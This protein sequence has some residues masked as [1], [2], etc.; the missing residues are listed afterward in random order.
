MNASFLVMGLGVFFA[1]AF[2]CAALIAFVIGPVAR[3]ASRLSLPARRA[4]WMLLAAAPAAAGATA[5]V[6]ALLP[7]FGLAPDH[8]LVHAAHHPHLCLHHPQELSVPAAI[9]ALVGLLRLVTTAVGE[10]RSWL[11]ARRV[12]S[13]LSSIARSDGPL[14]VFPGHTP[15]AFV[16]GATRPKVFVSEAMMQLP[17]PLL[18]P[19]LAHERCHAARRHLLARLVVRLLGALHVPLV[20]RRISERLAAAHE[21]EADEA[22]RAATGDGI[23]VAESLLRLARARQQAPAGA[24]GFA[25]GVLQERVSALL[26]PSTK[27][28]SW[29]VTLLLLSGASAAGLALL[30]PAAVHHAFETVLGWLH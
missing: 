18:D 20:A 19:A 4:L 9:V 17:R 6:T 1:A 25:D 23:L 29:P 24:V 15:T 27:R 28:M 12:S 10:A 3:A 2:F 21:L 11:R 30:S 8:C 5:L 16:L 26:E 22:A 13:S 14:T 7:S